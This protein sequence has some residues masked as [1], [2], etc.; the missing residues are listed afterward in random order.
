MYKVLFEEKDEGEKTP[1]EAA[2]NS[3]GDPSVLNCE[4]KS[5]EAL[6]PSQQREKSLALRD[7]SLRQAAEA[8]V[9]SLGASQ[10]LSSFVCAISPFRVQRGSD[11]ESGLTVDD[12]T[13]RLLYKALRIGNH[14]LRPGAQTPQSFEKREAEKDAQKWAALFPRAG[15]VC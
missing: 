12:L 9:A 2:T 14:F 8:A 4:T 10:G 6:S 1:P 7:Q 15:V 13:R 5:A 11:E 3:C